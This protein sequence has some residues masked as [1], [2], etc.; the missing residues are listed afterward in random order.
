M[1][2]L[3]I[4]WKSSVRFIEL[5]EAHILFGLSNTSCNKKGKKYYSTIKFQF[6]QK[7]QGCG[8]PY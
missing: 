8:K 1:I 7:K 2:V 6:N 5:N 3:K 4:Q